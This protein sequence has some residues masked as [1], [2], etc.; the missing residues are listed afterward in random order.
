RSEDLLVDQIE[1]SGTNPDNVMSDVGSGDS[2]RTIEMD[3]DTLRI[4]EEKS[5][6]LTEE[7]DKPK[8]E[9]SSEINSEGEKGEDLQEKEQEVIEKNTNKEILQEQDQT[10]QYEIMQ[11]ETQSLVKT[12]ETQSLVETIQNNPTEYQEIEA[13][14]TLVAHKKRNTR[15][16]T[17]IGSNN[18]RHKLYKKDEGGGGHSTSKKNPLLDKLYQRM[19]DYTDTA[20]HSGHPFTIYTQKTQNKQLMAT[21]LDYIF[22][23]N[24]YIQFCQD[25]QTLFGNS[26]HL[27][28]KSTFNMQSQAQYASYWKFN[29]KC[30]MNE[31]IKKDIEEELQGHITIDTWDILKNR[32]QA[33]IRQYKP[34]SSPKKKVTKLYKRIA[35]LQ[36]VII[37]YPEREGL[38]IQIRSNACWIETSLLDIVQIP[39]K[40]VDATLVNILQYAKKTYEKLY[41]LDRVNL[42]AIIEFSVIDQTVSEEQNYE[43]VKEITAK[44]IEETIESLAYNKAPGV[45]GLSYEFYKRMKV[46][47]ISLTN[48]D[49]KIFLKIIANS[50]NKICQTI[51]EKGF[52]SHHS[53]IDTVLDVLSVLR[54][55]PDQEKKYWMAFIDQQ[56]AFDRISHH[57]ADA[58]LI[59]ESFKVE[60]GVRQ[61]D[62][63]SPLLFIIAFEPFL[64]KLARNLQGIKVEKEYFKVAA[65]ADDLTVG[66]GSL[67]DWARFRQIVE[68]YEEASNSKI[69]KTKSNSS[70]NKSS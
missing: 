24:D 44:K 32:I 48:C 3:L 68:R 39:N 53:T 57:I 37:R 26:D 18:E 27:L 56:K 63:L 33:K 46:R 9:D 21:R 59:L 7:K 51:I 66:I 6:K 29:T 1:G 10:M 17:G 19:E 23:D 13:D 4:E 11:A 54:N 30:L 67:E 62:P 52:V 34:C 25:T 42:D 49:A 8:S 65:Y 40:V 43:L 12:I 60:Y 31:N 22:V 69:N 47:P 70:N 38:K 55:Q 45:D 36:E 2:E 58:G 50:V 16:A 64:Q 5:N 35:E 61:G 28:V 15:S 41:K 14:F 20:N